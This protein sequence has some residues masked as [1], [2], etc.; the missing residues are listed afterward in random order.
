MM[1]VKTMIQI[2]SMTTNQN[3]PTL[4]LLLIQWHHPHRLLS[5]SLSC[6]Q[7]SSLNCSLNSSLNCSLNSKLS[8]NLMSTNLRSSNLDSNLSTSQSTN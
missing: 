4:Q 3:Y 7:S 5:S 6:S 8:Y 1:K 2:I